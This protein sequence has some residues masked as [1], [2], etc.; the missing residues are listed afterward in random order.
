MADINNR[1]QSILRYISSVQA[2]NHFFVFCYFP[3]FS[4]LSKH[5]V[6]YWYHVHILQVSLQIILGDT[7]TSE[8]YGRDLKNVTFDVAVS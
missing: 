1:I 7:C 4:K 6:T 5:G 2:F 3:I 8:I